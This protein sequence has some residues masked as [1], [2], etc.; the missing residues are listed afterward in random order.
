MTNG[1]TRVPLPPRPQ[2]S[3]GAGITHRGLVRERNEDAILVETHRALWAIADGMGG[4]GHG[5][6]A[7]GIVVEEMTHLEE[8]LEPATLLCRALCRA[9]A[10]VRDR[11]AE[12]GPMGATVVALMIRSRHADVAWV[13]DSRAY[14][15]RRNVLR[16]LTRDHSVVR[17]LL[18][19]GDLNLQQARRHPERH[20]VTR[21]I[22]GASDVEI[23]FASTPLVPGD[24]LL[25]CSDGL[26][27]CVDENRINAVLGLAAVPEDACRELLCHTLSAGASDNVSIIAVFFRES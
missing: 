27:S 9:N 18:D 23:E 16:P 25:L 19:R 15:L 26:T 12:A 14:L 6:V 20:V 22:G 13:G 1:A 4:Y 24:R 17:E 10:R 7:A 21:A 3:L 8:G 11:A 5:D 2:T